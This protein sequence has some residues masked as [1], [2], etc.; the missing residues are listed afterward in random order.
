MMFNSA[1]TQRLTGHLET[2]TQQILQASHPHEKGLYWLSPHYTDAE[3][4]GFQVTTDLFQ[5]NS[6][7]A[8]FFLGRYAYSRSEADLRIAER[9]MDVVW[10]HLER[11]PPQ[12]FGLFTGVSGIIYTYIRLHE[13]GSKGPY[14]R[15]AYELCFTYQDQ[16][17]QRTIKADLL[18][19][20]SGT[21]F[22]LTLLYH[23]MQERVLLD[24]IQQLID[25]LV[26]EARPS[27]KGL[28]WDYNKSKSAYDSLTGFSH[29]ASGI[30]Y[31]LLQVAAY[32]DNKALVYLAEEALAYEMQYFDTDFEN[33]L[34]LRLGSHRLQTDNI[35]HW[36]LK[37]FRPHIRELNSWAHGAAGGGLARLAAWRATGKAAYL[38]Q[39]RGI[40]RKCSKAILHSDRPDYTLCSGYTGL[41]PFMLAYPHTAQD[42]SGELLLHVIDKAQQQYEAIGSYNSYIS[43]GP[44]DYGLL[45]GITGIGYSILQLLDSGMPS[46]L[47]PKLPAAHSPKQPGINLELETLQLGLLEKYYPLTMQQLKQEP[48]MH[49]NLKRSTDLRDFEDKLMQ[50]LPSAAHQWLL[51]RVF[52]LE[53]AR[54]KQWKQHKGYLCYSKK[55]EYIKSKIEKLAGLEAKDV[56]DFRFILSD[57]VNL[58]V[59][60]PEVRKKLDLPTDKTAVLFIADEW[61]VQTTYIGQ[62]STLILQ[63]VEHESLRGDIL[64]ESVS[65]RL[66]AY[67]GKPDQGASLSV[68]IST[69]V[70]LLFRSG[71]LTIE[72]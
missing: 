60:H 2:V 46:V 56:S 64:C 51:G 66:K 44:D 19:G 27:E 72:D 49:K 16:L 45:S 55:N 6:G 48:T 17:V 4:Y 15:R 32:F 65:N 36:E 14:L 58:Y 70:Q 8:L 50:Q 29:G 24:M 41:L 39:C 52:A 61:G 35:H 53:H 40:A 54:N 62:L 3:Q 28:K 21:L 9:T 20:Y 5:G 47:S 26:A 1:Q 30:A 13:L 69:Q 11:H 37:N 12:A 31:T 23:H 42:Y 22:V 63:Q 10:D 59:L 38:D 18:S 43:A 67:I 25:R 33:W 7:I 68:H 71:I 34:D 57:H